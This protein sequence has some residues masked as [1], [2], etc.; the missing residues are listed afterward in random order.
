MADADTFMTASANPA[1]TSRDETAAA[2]GQGEG[3]K[4]VGDFPLRRRR[5]EERA[6]VALPPPLDVYRCENDGDSAEE[7]E[8]NNEAEA[9]DLRA[10]STAAAT[11]AKMKGCKR[12]AAKAGEDDDTSEDEEEVVTS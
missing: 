10:S 3:V 6:S 4:S 5:G 7:E 11:A 12:W 8:E 1:A 2:Y 9:G